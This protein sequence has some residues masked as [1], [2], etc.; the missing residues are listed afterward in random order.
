MSIF[1]Y[2]VLNKDNKAVIAVKCNNEV[3]YFSPEEIC[4]MILSKLKEQAEE[5]LMKKVTKAVITV[6]AHFDGTQRQ[7]TIDAGKIAGLEVLRVINEPTAAA[8]A[9]EI[10][11]KYEHDCNILVYDFGG[12]TFDVSIVTIS[13]GK[14]NVRASNGEAYLGGDDITNRLVEYFVKRFYQDFSVELHNKLKAIERLKTQAEKTKIMLSSILECNTEVDCIDGENDLEYSMTRSVFE[15]LNKDLFHKTIECVEKT[16]AESELKKENIDEIL[17]VGGITRIPFVRDLVKNY[18]GKEPNVS[19][20]P[21]EAVAIGAARQAAISDKRNSSSKFAS[22]E[23]N[24]VCSLSLGIRLRNGNMSVIVPRNTKIPVK[25]EKIYNTVADNQSTIKIEIFEGES[26]ICG[27]NKFLADF[28]LTDIRHA[29]KGEVKC[30]V[31]FDIDESGI[32]RAT[33]KEY[34][35]SN[36]VKILVNILKNNLTED[37]IQKMIA[38]AEQLRIRDENKREIIKLKITLQEK[39]YFLI[40]KFSAIVRKKPEEKACINSCTETIRWLEN[41]ANLSKSDLKS[42]IDL[43]DGMVSRYLQNIR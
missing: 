38:Q 13:N 14:I 7:A 18:F 16:L 27:E 32:L 43:L 28:R 6:P 4:A 42:R 11:N 20:H 26:T 3:R 41:Y 9:F 35:T 34:G 29:P 2:T 22:V 40:D 12:G 19:I 5:V 10:D 24:D 39:C 15:N 31:T 21:T 25:T 17:L 23:L 36:T 8:L 33:A 37:E 1:P 30:T